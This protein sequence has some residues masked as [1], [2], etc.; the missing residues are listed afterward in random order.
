M[1]L[2]Y[3]LQEGTLVTIE[4]V[5]SGLACRCLCPG[6]RQPLLAKKG[7]SRLH[8]F[9][10]FN[11]PECRGGV[12]T[13]L[14]QICKEILL[15][16][17]AFTLPAYYSSKGRKMCEARTIAMQHVYLEKRL[18]DMIPDI[19]LECEG[20]S[21]LV[22]IE[23]SHPVDEK[24]LKKI[25][26]AGYAVLSF[27]ARKMVKERFAA[28]DYFLTGEAF[29]HELL[30]GTAFKKWLHN[31]K[32]KAIERQQAKEKARR[33]EQAFLQDNYITTPKGIVKEFRSFKK[34]NGSDL[35][36]VENCPITARTWQSGCK[37]GEP[38]ATSDDCK[39]CV[40]CRKLEQRA[41]P[42]TGFIKYLFPNKVDCTGHLEK[43]ELENFQISGKG[44]KEYFQ[45]VGRFLVV[46]EQRE[47]QF[48][49][50]FHTAYS[51]YLHCGSA[52]IFNA[53]TGEL[54]EQ[55]VQKPSRS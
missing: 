36:Y 29:Q 53:Q 1:K 48:F 20:R 22:E 21:L 25:R 15:H 35:F 49:Y 8:H 28:G 38:Y 55:K 11:S 2:P 17:K 54:I 39:T 23:V 42:H 41:Y 6:C 31:P 24:K 18:D 50:R 52:A 16:K 10:H 5:E 44:P 12:E 19:I 43:K 4:Q 45:A 40:F 46:N 30:Y 47:E 3:G 14:H 33:N 32:Y 34:K 13:P 26:K 37:A 7:R 27:D 51:H 9:A